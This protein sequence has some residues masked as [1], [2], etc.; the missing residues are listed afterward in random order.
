MKPTDYLSHTNIYA[1]IIAL[2]IPH[3]ERGAKY[4]GEYFIADKG[5]M[6]DNSFSQFLQ[7]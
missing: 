1:F 3:S 5:Q 2:I 7:Y 4:S 6:I